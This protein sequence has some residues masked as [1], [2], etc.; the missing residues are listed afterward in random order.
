M[1]RPGSLAGP[2]EAYLFPLE[3][4]PDPRRP[5]DRLRWFRWWPVRSTKKIMGLYSGMLGP[6]IRYNML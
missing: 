6:F 4:G 3:T 5:A 1:T 2:L